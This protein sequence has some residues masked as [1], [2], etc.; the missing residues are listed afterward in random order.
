[1]SNAVK[2]G[3]MDKSDWEWPFLEGLMNY[4]NQWLTE[5]LLRM[6]PCLLA[7][8]CKNKAKL[9]IFLPIV[10][11]GNVYETALRTNNPLLSF[12]TPLFNILYYSCE[13]WTRRLKH[14]LA[15]FLLSFRVSTNRE[16][17]DAVYFLQT[18]FQVDY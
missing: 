15:Y 16:T 17:S 13:L 7:L 5:S 11:T 12:K 14:S 10:W 9:Y 18:L 8:L 2:Y 1:M 3:L 4:E 6:Q